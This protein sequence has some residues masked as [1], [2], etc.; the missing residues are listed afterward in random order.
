MSDRAINVLPPY[1]LYQLF[2]FLGIYNEV[3][4]ISSV[5]TEFCHFREYQ[6]IGFSPPFSVI[7][8]LTTWYV[9][10]HPPIFEQVSG[11]VRGLKIE[12]RTI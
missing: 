9:Y 7:P 10:P 11:E 12:Y 2:P 4:T 1:K 8:R 3:F 5:I 6:G